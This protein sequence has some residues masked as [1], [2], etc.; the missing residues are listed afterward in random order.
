MFDHLTDFI[1]S[2]TGL[3]AAV[4][5]LLGGMAALLQAWRRWRDLWAKEPSGNESI[6]V[7]KRTRAVVLTLIG[8]V[9]VLISASIF[10]VRAT[11]ETTSSLSLTQQ[12][13][14]VRFTTAA[15]SAFNKKDYRTAIEKTEKCIN[16]FQG[17]ANREQAALKGQG[18]PYPPVGKASPEDKTVIFARGLLKIIWG[19]SKNVYARP[20]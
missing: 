16:E 1:N 15:W 10:S 12:P 17:A 2:F 14:N 6:A 20:L 9:L 4:T 7:K 13:L 5:A 19:Q 8:I 3:V 18:A 11:G